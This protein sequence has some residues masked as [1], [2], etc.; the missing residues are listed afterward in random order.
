MTL[1]CAGLL[2][3]LGAMVYLAFKKSSLGAAAAVSTLTKTKS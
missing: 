2:T 1:L 3:L